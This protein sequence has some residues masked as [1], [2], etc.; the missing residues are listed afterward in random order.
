M[1]DSPSSVTLAEAL[2]GYVDARDAAMV[3]ARRTLSISETDAKALLFVVGNPGTRPGA[4]R[5]YLGITG[6]GVTTLTDRLVN[7]GVVQRQ[8]DA[9]DRRVNRITATIDIAAAPWSELRRFDDDFELAIDDADRASTDEL[10][11]LLASLT[12]ATVNARA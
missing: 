4:L 6:A 9:D 1:S 11:E 10:A 3:I 7:R 2:R 5:D 8:V 12:T